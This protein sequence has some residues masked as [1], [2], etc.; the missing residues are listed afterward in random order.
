MLKSVSH[1]FERLAERCLA[2]AAGLLAS[3]I[4]AACIRHEAEQQTQL[5]EL[6][7]S[8]DADGL[9]EAAAQLR[10]RARLLTHHNPAAAG[11]KLL[12]D[13]SDSASVESTH[14]G[15][16]DPA[17]VSLTLNAAGMPASSRRSTGRGKRGLPSLTLPVDEAPAQAPLG[18]LT[19]P[20]SDATAS[21]EERQ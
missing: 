11:E 17:A 7:R 6:A 20:P 18:S 1:L 15:V 9:P 16:D 8:F 4:E 13:L 2:L 10:D 21:H 19:L 12:R 3:K 14:Q 5:E